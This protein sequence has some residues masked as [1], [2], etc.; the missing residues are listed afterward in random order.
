MVKM[1][2]DDPQKEEREDGI[3]GT[4]VYTILQPRAQSLLF[5]CWPLWPGFTRLYRV[6]LLFGLG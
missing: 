5:I 3:G 1:P 2:Q 4:V 6:Y